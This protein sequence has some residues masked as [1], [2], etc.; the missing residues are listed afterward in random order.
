MRTA[1]LRGGVLFTKATCF[2]RA[3]RWTRVSGS[4]LPAPCLRRLLHGWLLVTH[5]LRSTGPAGSVTLGRGRVVRSS[6]R[7]VHI[8]VTGCACLYGGWGSRLRSPGPCRQ[9]R[10]PR[11]MSHRHLKGT[12]HIKAFVALG[13]LA[14]LL[15]V[16]LF[17]VFGL[18]RH[19]SISHCCLVNR[20]L[21]DLQHEECLTFPDFGD[22]LGVS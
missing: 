3:P 14:I 19:H 16:C 10:T 8:L 21:R 6:Y 5:T 7:T 9:V 22:T 4:R 1:H 2:P 20:V 15:F 18:L 17:V 12:G 13:H 11:T